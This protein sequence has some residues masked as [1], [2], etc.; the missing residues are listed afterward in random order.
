MAIKTP[1]WLPAD[2]YPSSLGWITSKGEV[3]KKQRFNTEEI[4]E[5]FLSVSDSFGKQPVVQMLTEAPS[6]QSELAPEVISHY[7]HSDEQ[8][9]AVVS[10]EDEDTF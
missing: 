9:E 7:Y 2:A 3:L 10:E 6:V 4:T 1:K 5:W 8:S